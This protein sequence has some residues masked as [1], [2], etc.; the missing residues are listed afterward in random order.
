MELLCKTI[1]SDP[2]KLLANKYN[3][4]TPFLKFVEDTPQYNWKNIGI[5]LVVVNILLGM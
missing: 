4:D 2:S 5:S 3:Y 1:N